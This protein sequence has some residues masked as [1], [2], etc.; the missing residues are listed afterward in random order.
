M[1]HIKSTGGK[2]QDVPEK[3]GVDT[4]YWISPILTRAPQEQ[5]A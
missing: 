2:R 3:Y 4:S 5:A 1:S